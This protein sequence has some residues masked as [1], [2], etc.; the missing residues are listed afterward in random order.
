MTICRSFLSS[1]TSCDS[2]TCWLRS[3]R[4]SFRIPSLR[5]RASSV[6]GRSAAFLA[7]PAV[8]PATSLVASYDLRHLVDGRIDLVELLSKLDGPTADVRQDDLHP[9][10][11]RDVLVRLLQQLLP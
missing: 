1:S 11:E 4:S 3:S 5:V 6:S 8:S 7:L 10:R 9:T 2:L